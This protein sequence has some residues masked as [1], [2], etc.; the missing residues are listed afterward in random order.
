LTDLVERTQRSQPGVR[1]EFEAQLAEARPSADVAL[2]LYRAAQ[3]GI[4]NAL[5]HG[6]ARTL[7]L[8]V[9]A[10]DDSIALELAD[11][12][13]GLPVGWP[14]RG[15]QRGLRWLA[16]RVESVGGQFQVEPGP[17]G[18]VCLRVRVPLHEPVEAA[19]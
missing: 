5:R 19:A 7:R 14:E 1:I 16:E 9:R 13:V 15:G 11:D 8:Q 12:G 4:T 2:T 10:A 18:G 3:E 6:Q 17:A